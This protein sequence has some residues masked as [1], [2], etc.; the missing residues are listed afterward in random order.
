M[1]YA[2]PAACQCPVRAAAAR[3][4]GGVAVSVTGR[5]GHF[6]AALIVMGVAVVYGG[7]T[8][9]TRRATCLRCRSTYA[10]LGGLFVSAA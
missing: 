2:E 1:E 6:L 3:A 8:V 7:I 10:A 5:S 9:T 4:V